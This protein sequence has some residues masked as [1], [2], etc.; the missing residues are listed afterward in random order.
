MKKI[1]GI[2]MAVIIVAALIFAGKFL[3]GAFMKPA[4]LIAAVDQD[5]IFSAEKFQN[6]LKQYDE[7][8]KEIR[9]LY[10]K[11][12][13]NLSD[14]QKSELLLSY[15]RQ[16]EQKRA[17]LVNPL[18]KRVEESIGL[19]AEKGGIKVVVDKKISVYGIKDITDEVIDLFQS[20]K[21]IKVKTSGG[22]DSGSPV[23]YFDQDVVRNLKIFR[24]ADAKLSA[25]YSDIQKQL[26][27][28]IGKLSEKEKE[29]IL[30]QY[31]VDFYK[32]RAELYG[33][34]NDKVSRAASNAAKSKGVSLVLDKTS[35]MYG[36]LNL[37]NEVVNEFNK[38]GGK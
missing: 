5:K 21:E 11:K 28:K 16:L 19:I 7:Y 36:G 15:Q 6:A 4:S 2:V 23:G 32:K 13:K 37:T 9:D 17:L 26:K 3:Y 1:I 38:L 31:E 12:S 34:I 24:D 30:N 18:K 35:V 33:P 8:G 20:S 10:N 27:D 14:R 22:K 25:I 29:K